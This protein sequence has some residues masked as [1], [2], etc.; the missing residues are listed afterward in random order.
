LQLGT[1]SGEDATPINGTANVPGDDWGRPATGY[2]L[3]SGRHYE[4]E[5][6][7]PFYLEI[8]PKD[9]LLV[10]F[11]FGLPDDPVQNDD[12][13][14]T[15]NRNQQ[16][17]ELLNN[18]PEFGENTSYWGE[19]GHSWIILNG[20]FDDSIGAKVNDDSLLHLFKKTSFRKY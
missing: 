1:S 15:Y 4:F 16:T 7:C 2:L 9:Q 18:S 11:I 12:R 14:R 17:Q 6:S 10:R 13:Q 8:E 3:V 19:G 5:I 20:D